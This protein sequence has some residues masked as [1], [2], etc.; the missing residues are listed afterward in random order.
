MGNYLKLFIPP[1]VFL[2][3]RVYS[4]IIKRIR[5][6][7]TFDS[8]ENSALIDAIIEKT[9]IAKENIHKE[10]RINI[11]AFRIFV[12]MA[13]GNCETKR[14]VDLGGA[15]GYHYFNAKRMHTSKE[16]NWVIV[17]TPLFCK[18]AKEISELSEIRFC[19]NV[20]DAFET[21]SGEVDLVYCSRALQYFG[22]PFAILKE[23]C[24]LS[25][26]NIFISGIPES[27]DNQIHKHVQTSKMSDNGPQVHKGKSPNLGDVEYSL[28][29][30]PTNMIEEVLN[31]K[32]S[33]ELRIDEEPQAHIFKGQ[34]IPFK[35]IW[36]VRRDIL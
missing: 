24:S 17:E 34:K 14:I 12:A 13:L 7:K 27:P 16:L 28:Q 23:I 1:I 25:P 20:S 19:D 15:A 6:Q 26:K 10:K 29:L 5:P 30:L 9:I 33:I 21:L 11:D 18:K 22:D 4:K 31:A 8:Y 35:G 32:Y 3:P 36:A 2:I